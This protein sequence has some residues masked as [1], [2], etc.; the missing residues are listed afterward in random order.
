MFLGTYDTTS[1]L[2]QRNYVLKPGR[3]EELLMQAQRNRNSSICQELDHAAGWTC[4]PAAE[5]RELSRVAG[6]VRE[7]G[8]HPSGVSRY[9]IEVV[10]VL[11][12]DRHRGYDEVVPCVNSRTNTD[13]RDGR[14]S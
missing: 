3:C 9:G 7:V 6:P 14:G 2:N 13:R 11:V 8:K 4:R 10:V 5:K 1:E 12:H